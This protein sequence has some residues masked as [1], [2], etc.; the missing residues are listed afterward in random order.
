MH[1]NLDYHRSKALNALLTEEID[2]TASGSRSRG[3]DAWLDLL[4]SPQFALMA[5]ACGVATFIVV[6][7]II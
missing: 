6:A 2:Q 5:I 1:H 3:S 4:P 7:H